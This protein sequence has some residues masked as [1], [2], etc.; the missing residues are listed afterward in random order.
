MET[1]SLKAAHV[2]VEDVRSLKCNF[3]ALKTAPCLR[4]KHAKSRSRMQIQ[5]VIIRNNLTLFL[6]AIGRRSADGGTG[7]FYT[8]ADGRRSA[9][10]HLPMADLRI[11]KSF[12]HRHFLHICHFIRTEQIHGRSGARRRRSR[13]P[14][15]PSSAPSQNRQMMADHVRSHKNLHL[16]VS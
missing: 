5:Q 6:S 7:H 11:G 4:R 14:P 10:T 15:L 3:A 8:S 1:M 2:F 9:F 12:T 16:D 13:A